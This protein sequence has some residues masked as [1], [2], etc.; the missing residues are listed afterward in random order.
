MADKSS[1]LPDFELEDAEGNGLWTPEQ[2]WNDL[3]PGIST[4]AAMEHKLG[5]DYVREDLGNAFACDYWDGYLRLTYLKN[6]PELAAVWISGKVAD[7][8]GIPT[9]LPELTSVYG[10]LAV[11]EF[12]KPSG[13]A[14]YE[15]SGLRVC[16]DVNSAPVS[17]KWLEFF[18]E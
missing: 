1:N 5:S 9:T 18:D 13:V 3:V 12:D 4:V 2:G 7:R 11:T 16:C 6:S 15:R 10:R 17:V 8:A 14:K